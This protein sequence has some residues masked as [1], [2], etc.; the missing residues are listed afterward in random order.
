MT[1]QYTDLWP[2]LQKDILGVL[3]ADAFIGARP[4]V[5]IE[6]G[7]TTS[8]INEEVA[9]V[10][11]A[12]S[13]GKNGVGFLVL[14]IERAEDEDVSNPFGPLKLTLTVQFVE[15]V[16]VNQGAVGTGIPI[17]I[18]AAR[19]VKILK[20]YTPVGFTQSLVA[21]NPVVNEFT[22][23]DNEDLRVG[24][25]EFTAREADGTP[26]MRLP[27]P[28]ISMT[29]IGYP[30]TVSVVAAGAPSIYYTTDGSHPSALNPQAQLYTGPVQITAPGMFRVRSFG[31]DGDFNTIPSDTAAQTFN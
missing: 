6:P 21:Q 28:V 4:G 12:G 31:A 20:L 24:H 22:D 5:L 23:K 14:P 30:Y 3:Q 25:I 13:D 16:P 1:M 7:D 26:L 10:V 19:A 11:G 9:K 18:Y 15:N 27:R 17:R 29:G 2:L 8:V